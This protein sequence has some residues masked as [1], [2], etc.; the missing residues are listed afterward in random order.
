MKIE[1]C[2][3]NSISFRII[4]EILKKRYYSAKQDGYETLFLPSPLREV[5][6]HGAATSVPDTSTEYINRN[7][8]LP[9][10]MLCLLPCGLL[11]EGIH[12]SVYHHYATCHL[13]HGVFPWRTHNSCYHDVTNMHS[14]PIRC[15]PL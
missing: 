2:L 13:S 6:H 7:H 15:S 10:P 4:S 14:L 3:N 8:P 11:P 1:N 9:S 12:F 5:P